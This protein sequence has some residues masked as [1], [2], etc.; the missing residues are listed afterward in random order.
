MFDTDVALDDA[1]I[2]ILDGLHTIVLT[3]ASLGKAQG[4]PKTQKYLCKF[5][6]EAFYYISCK[7]R[8]S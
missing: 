2:T 3:I 8:I 5:K 6:V 1:D 4:Q 7:K